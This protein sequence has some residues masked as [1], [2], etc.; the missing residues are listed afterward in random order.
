MDGNGVVIEIAHKIGLP[1]V[2]QPRGNQR[3]KCA[4]QHWVGHT[5]HMLRDRR[6][7]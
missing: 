1:V 2:L 5:L 6:T 4:L 3:I 7:L